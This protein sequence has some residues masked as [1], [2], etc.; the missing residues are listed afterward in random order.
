MA[1]YNEVKTVFSRLDEFALEVRELYRGI[2]ASNTSS[3]FFARASNT[4]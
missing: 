1:V 4:D 2:E 3:N